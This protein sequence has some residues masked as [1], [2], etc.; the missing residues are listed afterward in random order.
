MTMRM[1]DM[2]DV[3]DCKQT[4]QST[5]QLNHWMQMAA[6]EYRHVVGGQD[7]FD[8]TQ[9][10]F[11][12]ELVRQCHERRLETGQG[13]PWGSQYERLEAGQ[14][15]AVREPQPVAPPPAAAQPKPPKVPAGGE[16]P[17]GYKRGAFGRLVPVAAAN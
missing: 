17:E 4:K 2:Q 15:Q 10:M 16:I 8:P 12:H 11:M 3:R 6:I 7:V 9:C 14:S 13:S 5:L 1:F